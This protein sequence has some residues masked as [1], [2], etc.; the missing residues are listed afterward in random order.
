MIRNIL[1]SF[2]IFTLILGASIA[3]AESISIS[4]QPTTILQGDPVLI[5]IHNTA[6]VSDI[7]KVT[8]FGVK[9]GVFMYKG[10]PSALAGVDLNKKIGDYMATVE[11]TNGD[12]IKQTITVGKR[13]IVEE[14]LGIPEKLGG[15]TKESQDNLVAN[16]AADK[17]KV[18][19][20]KT[21]IKALWSKAFVEPLSKIFITSPYGY[22]RKTG[23]YSIPHKG[24]DY[25]AVVG[26]EIYAVNRG[27]VRIAQS[28]T[29]Y[30]KSIFI[31]HG[32]G[33][34]SY[35]LHL[36]KYKVKVGQ[37]VE[38][39]QTIGLSGDTGYTLGAH[40]HLG[41]RINEVTVDPVKFFKLFK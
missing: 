31:D 17:K 18:T 24:T 14:P 40:L 5:Q 33:L 2:V 29:D 30:G 8:L 11:M 13:D 41:I 35:Y 4:I 23:E 34:V 26:T 1:L 20:L 22:S 21:N 39:G 25:R 12:I 3:H 16:L 32:L 15:N 38:A 27:V 36:S 10:V 9:R 19:N 37:V 7:K 6:K 28:Y